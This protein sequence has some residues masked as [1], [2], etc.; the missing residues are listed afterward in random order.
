M[1]L[2]PPRGNSRTTQIVA[3]D[4]EIVQEQA[5]ALGRLGRALEAALAALA[6]YDSAHAEYDAARAQ[7]VQAA[8]QA[9]W[10]FIV[11]REACGLRDP[12]PVIREYRVPAEVHAR[13]GA[14][15]QH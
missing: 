5:H 1:N 6:D 14:I 7:L 2:R 8:S 4:Y 3:L 13:M 11:Q 12:R 10:C 15:P 9:L